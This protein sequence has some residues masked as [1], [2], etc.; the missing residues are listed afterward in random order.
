LPA[1]LPVDSVGK[2]PMIHHDDLKGRPGRFGLRCCS[3]YL[4][5]AVTPLG[6]RLAQEGTL[7]ARPSTAYRNPADYGCQ[8]V[9]CHLGRVVRSNT[10]APIGTESLAKAGI[11]Q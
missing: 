2:A 9:S 8:L 6:C 4:I 7:L 3:F 10:I 11:V 5:G 1:G